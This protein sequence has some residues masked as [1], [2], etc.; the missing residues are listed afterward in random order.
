L[1]SCENAEDSLK[2][3]TF[4][5]SY[6]MAFY[7]AFESHLN[8]SL[9]ISPLLT[10]EDRVFPLYLP[11]DQDLLD[12]DTMPLKE[13]E[14]ILTKKSFFSNPKG[15][16]T[17]KPTKKHFLR[18]L[19]ILIF[20]FT[21]ACLTILSLVFLAYLAIKHSKLKTFITGLSLA[22]IPRANSELTERVVCHDPWVNMVLTGITLTGMS[23]WVYKE[24]K[25]LAITKGL[26]FSNKCGLYLF[27]SH[28]SYYVPIKVLDT[29]GSMHMFGR[30]QNVQQLTL[31]IV[32]NWFWDQL[33]IDWHESQILYNNR[34]LLLPTKIDIP[35]MYKWMMRN[36]LTQQ[37][38]ITLM[39]KQNRQWCP[40]KENSQA[41]PTQN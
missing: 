5:F 2:P 27:I 14:A 3:P 37:H 25:S 35:I 6:N 20:K 24:V 26:R 13:M 17:S 15:Y 39:I 28:G 12:L 4:Y 38:D 7:G 18:K 41:Q 22:Q 30:T 31:N 34:V 8:T 29:T 10:T 23:I 9:D 1:G 40:V 11:P 21:C 32:R 33:V 16:K 36:I 19:P